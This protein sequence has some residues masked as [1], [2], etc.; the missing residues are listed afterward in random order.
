MRSIRTSC[1][2]ARST[3]ASRTSVRL[4]DAKATM[5]H[6]ERQDLVYRQ[7]RWRSLRRLIRGSGHWHCQACAGPAEVLDHIIPV[8]QP[9]GAERAFYI[10][11]VQPLCRAHHLAKTQ[12]ID[13]PGSNPAAYR[14]DLAHKADMRTAEFK[15]WVTEMLQHTDAQARVGE[16]SLHAQQTKQKWQGDI[17]C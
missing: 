4:V 16:P 7:A 15:R 12:T 9:I 2:T 3:T 5:G 10:G 11:N 6:E 17:S 1:S 14:P 8:N 13:A